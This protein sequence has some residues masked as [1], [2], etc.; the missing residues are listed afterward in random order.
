MVKV[1][2]ENMRIVESA[3]VI[4]NVSFLHY[5]RKGTAVNSCLNVT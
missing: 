5:K 3:D 4:R 1:A 2:N